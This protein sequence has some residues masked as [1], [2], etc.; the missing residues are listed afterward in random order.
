MG[1]PLFDSAFGSFV[2]D[3]VPVLK[4]N[5]I[6]NA[7]NVGCN[8]IRQLKPRKSSV[9]NHELPL[10]NDTLFNKRDY[11]AAE[12]FWSPQYIQHSAHIP[13]GREGLFNLVTRR[14]PLLLSCAQRFYIWS[15][16]PFSSQDR[17]DSNHE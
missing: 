16:Q 7:K 2:L 15:S 10:R 1:R 14:Q 8:P 12:K 17:V 4:K 3:Y 11:A 13:P 6:L 5:A 9:D